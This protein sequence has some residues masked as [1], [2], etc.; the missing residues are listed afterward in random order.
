MKTRRSGA[1]ANYLARCGA[2]CVHRDRLPLLSID[3]GISPRALARSIEGLRAAG[4]A[5]VAGKELLLSPPMKK[6]EW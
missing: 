1:L 6:A 5:S 2:V 3:L 4:Q